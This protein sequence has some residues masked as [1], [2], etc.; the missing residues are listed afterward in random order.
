MYTD[1]QSE[2]DLPESL[3]PLSFSIPIP[4]QEEEAPLW[5]ETE[6][7]L[8]TEGQVFGF[9]RQVTADGSC[10]HS[11]ASCSDD[12]RSGS[13][14]GIAAIP[15]GH[16]LAGSSDSYMSDQSDELPWP[17]SYAQED[18]AL[19]APGN[20]ASGGALDLWSY[21]RSSDTAQFPS[22]SWL[23]QPTDGGFSSAESSGTDLSFGSAGGESP[24]TDVG[25]GGGF[26]SDRLMSPGTFLGFGSAGVESPDTDVG[27]GS[28]EGESSGNDVEAA[29]LSAAHYIYSLLTKQSPP[30]DTSEPI[31][32]SSGKAGLSRQDLVPPPYISLDEATSWSAPTDVMLARN[33]RSAASAGREKEDGAV[34]GK[35]RTGTRSSERVG[36]GTRD[37]HGVAPKRSRCRRSPGTSAGAERKVAGRSV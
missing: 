22:S 33:I 8:G 18:W 2:Q 29:V 14:L 1:P 9:P 27:F 6:G 32:T 3:G 13:Q 11:Y 25:A 31:E 23:P 17:V 36:R 7:R 19:T 12:S 21:H 28:A 4:A 15:T 34:H 24:G 10:D 5:Y 30:D 16:V 37:Q 26:G 35:G 20:C